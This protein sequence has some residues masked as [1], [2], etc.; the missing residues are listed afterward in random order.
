ME[1]KARRVI[2]E[3][4]YDG[5]EVGL[6]ARV[7]SISYTDNDK[8]RSDEI[9]VVFCDRNA[10]WLMKEFIPEKE[11]DLD[12]TMYFESWEHLGAAALKY[13]CGNFTI[14]D[15]SYSGAP[16]QC[17]IKGVSIPASTDF[18]TVP[19]SKT[20]E[21]STVKQIAE[22]KMSEYSMETLFWYGDTPVLEKIA[23]DNQTDSDFLYKLCED[24]GLNLKVYKKGLVIFDKK[25]YEPRGVKKVFT[26]T[27]FESFGWNT[28]L[29]GTY[30]GAHLAYTNPATKAQTDKKDKNG[31]PIPKTIDILIGEGPRILYMSEKADSEDD[32]RRKAAARINS[33][34]EKAVTMSFTAMANVNLFATDNFEVLGMGRCDGKYYTSSVT[35]SLSQSGESMSVEGYR[36]FD[37]M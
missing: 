11:H 21:Q 15:I 13:H 25:I 33:E 9:S 17:T 27:D 19:K 29:T 16:Y 12:V 31:N 7:E 37:R 32:A 26:K 2:A 36:I 8:G 28:T 18:L 5:K 34:N 20:W 14:D 22:E 10:D 30:T 1:G 35:H 23:Q 4:L 24:N 3:I 6:S